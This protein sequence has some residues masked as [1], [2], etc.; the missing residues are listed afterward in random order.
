MFVLKPPVACGWI[1][2]TLLSYISFEHLSHATSDRLAI[3]VRACLTKCRRLIVDTGRLDGVQRPRIVCHLLIVYCI[4]DMVQC[5]YKLFL[6]SGQACL[7]GHAGL[8]RCG[9]VHDRLVP[10]SVEFPTPC[11]M[12]LLEG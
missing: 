10:A 8:A 4:A 5:C 3:V 12:D 6:V 9:H 2:A 1:Y 11:K 7:H